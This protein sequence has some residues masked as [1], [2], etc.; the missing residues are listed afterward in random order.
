LLAH[1]HRRLGRGRGG[2]RG[3]RRR[4]RRRGRLGR[5]RGRGRRGSGGGRRGRLGRGGRRRGRLGRGGRRRGPRLARPAAAAATTRARGLRAV[6]VV[7]AALVVAVAL[8][9]VARLGGRTRPG[10]GGPHVEGGRGDCGQPENGKNGEGGE[11][12][13]AACQLLL[14][15]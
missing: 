8:A 4:G 1:G 10:V 2:G 15:A 12:P 7:F 13:P 11:S 14:L 3:G 6:G 5:R 9:V